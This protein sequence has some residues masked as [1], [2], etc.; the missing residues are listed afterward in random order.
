MPP[1]RCRRFLIHSNKRCPE[2]VIWGLSIMRHIHLDDGLRLRFPGRSEDFDQGV[3]IGMIAVLMDQGLGEFSRWI[4]R[5]NLSQV[6]AIA[7]Q[8]G[9]R[10]EEVGGDEEWADITF[11]YG[12]A[13]SKPKLKL[14]H[15]VG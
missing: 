9:Y 15:S 10:L 6:E 11:L 14:V 2:R 7:K 13:K 4:A 5:S 1:S 3:E 8:M 12:T